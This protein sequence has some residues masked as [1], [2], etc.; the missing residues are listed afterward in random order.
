MRLVRTAI[1]AGIITKLFQEARKPHNQEKLRRAW[2]QATNKD[3]PR[4]TR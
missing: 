1:K 4:T 2:H 3:Q